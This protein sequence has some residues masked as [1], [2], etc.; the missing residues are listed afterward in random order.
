MISLGMLSAGQQA[1]LRLFS[2]FADCTAKSAAW[3]LNL[4]RLK[5][6]GFEPSHL[7]YL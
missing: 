7:G 2:Q 3:L 4:L 1:L 6:L 5:G